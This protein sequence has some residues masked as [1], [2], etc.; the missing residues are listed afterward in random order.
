[1]SPSSQLEDDD[2]ISEIAAYF[3][4]DEDA[5]ES[6]LDASESEWEHGADYKDSTGYASGR[7]DHKE[8]YDWAR[9]K[10]IQGNNVYVSEYAQN[11]PDGW[12]VVWEKQSKKDIRDASGT[13]KKT[14]EVIMQPP[15]ATK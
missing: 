10:Q 4:V 8:F 5:A 12:N 1:M 7:F 14:N 2:V 3:D 11:V 15:E 6:L 9:Y 13:Q